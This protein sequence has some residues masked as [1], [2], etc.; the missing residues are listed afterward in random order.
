MTGKNITESL[1]T[2]L[3][4]LFPGSVATA[5]TDDISGADPA[6]WLIRVGYDTYIADEH[7]LSHGAV[8]GVWELS[9]AVQSRIGVRTPDEV[10]DLGVRSIVHYVR[11]HGWQVSQITFGGDDE[12]HEAR[13][14]I[15][16]RD[17]LFNE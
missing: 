8:G 11:K 6:A 16:K 4:A 10:V 1:A 14:N 17:G 2:G 9:V 3:A 5:D 7:T 13:I 12:F 15:F